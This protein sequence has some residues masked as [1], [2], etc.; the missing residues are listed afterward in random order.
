MNRFFNLLQFLTRIR[1]KKNLKYDENMGSSMFYFPVI[2]I[3]IG[4]LMLAIYQITKYLVSTELSILIAILIVLFEAIIT[5]GLHID[6]FGDTFDGLFSYRPKDRILEI[7]KDP[8]MGTNGI[9]AITFLII[10]KI[11]SVYLAIKT[12]NIWAIFS[13]PVVARLSAL[14]MSYRAVSARPKGMGELFIGK[15]NLANLLAAILITV[16]SVMLSCFLNLGDIT[17]SIK[18]LLGII[19]S[20]LGSILLRRESYKKIDGVTGDILGCSIEMGEI[21]FIVSTLVVM[22]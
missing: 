1:I 17:I 20:I 13:M 8:T 10:I 7:M 22:S 3:V 5:G 2:G 6:G 9:L 14:I 16:I 18:A 4:I 11:A 21:V 15:C 19:V 12:G